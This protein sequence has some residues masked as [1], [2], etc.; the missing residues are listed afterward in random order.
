MN[1]SRNL[2]ILNRIEKQQKLKK[3]FAYEILV[4]FFIAYVL[5]NFVFVLMFNLILYV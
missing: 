1:N 4:I 5:A 3:R 2:E